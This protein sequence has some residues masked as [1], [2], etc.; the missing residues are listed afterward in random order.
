MQEWEEVVPGR[1]R[2]IYNGDELADALLIIEALNK[3]Q[4][5]SKVEKILKDQSHSGASFGIVKALI[6]RF[7][8]RGDYFVKFIDTPA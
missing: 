8:K 4:D 6:K 2:D 1:V 3:G 7:C 5:Y